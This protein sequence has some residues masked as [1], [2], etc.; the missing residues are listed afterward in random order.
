MKKIKQLTKN[1]EE[2]S[3][4]EITFKITNIYIKE[5]GVTLKQLKE[6]AIN[7]FYYD[8][9]HSCLTPKVTIKRKR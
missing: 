4:Y 7:D 3:E 6:D 8:M 2:L 5:R 1:R 9:R